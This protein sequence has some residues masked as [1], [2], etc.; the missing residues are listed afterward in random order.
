MKEFRF[1]RVEFAGSL[2]DLGT[3]LPLAMGMIMVNGLD[4]VGLFV[5]VGL[6]YVLG[7]SYYRVPIAVQP[8]KVISAYA[9]VTAASQ[10]QIMASGWLMAACLLFL[11]LTGLVDNVARMIPKPVIRGVQLS[12]GILLMSK[13]AGFIAGTSPFQQ[14]QGMAEPFLAF[15]MVGPVPV[16]IIIGALLGAA[17][18]LLLDNKRYPAGL[19]VVA[20]GALC[21]L[22]LGAA[23]GLGKL[24]TG[25][26]PPPLLP[27]GFPSGADFTLALFT[28]VLP[29]LPMTVGNAVI[30]NRDLSLEYFG[31]NS[32]RVTD[33]ALCV[34][35]GIANAV[36]ALLG[37]MPL[38]HGAGGLA[39]H[40]RF[41]ARTGG[42][43]II[44]G[45][46]FLALAILFG[47][48][49]LNILHLLP[50]AALGVLLIF[51]GAQLGLTIL[52]MRQRD[53]LFV[54][55]VMVGVALAFNLAWAF[56]VGL[57]VAWVL[58]RGVSI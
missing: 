38:C 19:V 55:L 42:S 12:T 26:N 51:A 44:I 36:G 46:I 5:T 4:P 16:G 39:A 37:G 10:A 52:D 32:R 30:A 45:A 27:F 43:N 2:G 17:A 49:I 7:G 20:A 28:L 50:M 23:S 54:I 34:T 3:L 15:Q 48:G 1:N 24:S 6:L 57:L 53:E 21:G 31:E 14:G 33:R 29:Q 25:F 11:G 41:G 13:G 58:R 47:A 35:M 8:M 40:Y 9:I 22:L 18:L 56:G